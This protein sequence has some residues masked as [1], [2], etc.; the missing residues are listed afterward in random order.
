MQ[1]GELRGLGR[2]LF[3]NRSGKSARTAL[4]TCSEASPA[5]GVGGEA[6]SEATG[7]PRTTSGLAS[8]RRL[9][10]G[11]RPPPRKP[12]SSPPGWQEPATSYFDGGVPPPAQ[13]QAWGGGRVFRRTRVNGGGLIAVRSEGA[14]KRGLPR[15]GWAAC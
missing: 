3:A 7:P 1:W 5:W 11:G 8:S 14:P 13:R 9:S 15:G 4:G 10:I 12:L 2:G 6:V